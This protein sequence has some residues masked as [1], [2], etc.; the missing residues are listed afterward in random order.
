MVTWSIVVASGVA[1]AKAGEAT[2]TKSARPRARA[3]TSLPKDHL[4]Y[5]HHHG[6]DI[7]RRERR[8]DKAEYP[9]KVIIK[10]GI[11]PTRYFPSRMHQSAWS[12]QGGGKEARA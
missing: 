10:V 9:T 4:P 6:D 7:P 5:D 2:S 3:R 12:N 11:V 8:Q 1:M